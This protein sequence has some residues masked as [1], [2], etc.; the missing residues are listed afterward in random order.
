MWS[1]MNE[2]KNR[3]KY[4]EYDNYF[5]LWPLFVL[6]TVPKFRFSS[7][8]F[9]KN[10]SYFLTFVGLCFVVQKDESIEKKKKN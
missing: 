5:K 2:N 8:I 7:Y 3:K 4:K 9:Q 1:Q 6:F 10:F